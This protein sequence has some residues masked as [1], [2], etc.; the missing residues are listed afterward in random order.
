[1]MYYR[2]NDN[3]LL[4]KH[5]PVCWLVPCLDN[6]SGYFQHQYQHKFLHHRYCYYR[7]NSLWLIRCRLD[8]DLIG[9]GIGH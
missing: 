1:V 6:G 8:F 5:R 2:Y 4:I 9:V 3:D 7:Q